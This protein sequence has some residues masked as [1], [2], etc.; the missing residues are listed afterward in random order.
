MTD[1]PPAGLP[2]RRPYFDPGTPIDPGAHRV[3]ELLLAQDGSATRLCETVAGGAVELRLWAQR[4]VD[5]PPGEVRHALPGGRFLERCTS[6]CAHGQVLMDNLSYVALEALPDELRHGLERGNAP[7]G[8]L[9]AGA[10][11]RRAF[12]DAP[13]VLDRLW[14]RVGLPDPAA[15]RAYVVATPDGPLMLIAETFRR[16][17]WWPG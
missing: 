14:S 6:L 4:I 17:L 16:G 8:H 9:L 1:L 11:T 7:I 3:L 15:S 10:W 5:D 2:Q 12:V 13:G